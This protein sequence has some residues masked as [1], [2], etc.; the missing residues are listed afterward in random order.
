MVAK[1][2]NSKSIRAILN[3]NENKVKAAEAELLLAAGFPRDPSRLSFNNKLERMELLTRQNESTKTNAMHVMLNFSGAD[4]ADNELLKTIAIDYMERIGFGNQPFLVY[5]HY[6]TAHPH[7][8]IATV[9]IAEGGSRIETHNIGRNQS[10]K[11]RKEMEEWYGLV[12]ADEQKKEDVYQ[13]KPVELA[14]VVYGKA[15]TK[16]AISAVVRDVVD[17]YKFTSLPE[18]NAVLRQFNIRAY[19]GA[20]DTQMFQKGGLVYGILDEQGLPV[21]IPIKA[22]SIYGSPTLKNLEKKYAPNETAR[23]PYGQRLK[24]LLDKALA[25]A[26]NMDDLNSQLRKQG[27]RILMREN[28]AGQVYGI[29]FLDNA[30]RVVFN[31][32]DLGKV[33]SALQFM[34]RLSG[35]SGYGEDSLL[36]PATPAKNNNGAAVKHPATE[37]PVIEKLLDTLL[38]TKYERNEPDPFRKKKKRRLQTD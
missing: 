15:S 38:Y 8:H 17:S 4:K 12:K 13:L 25:T 11:A 3:Y 35:I 16:A 27:I 24:H 1:I 9:N 34:T 28:A 18:L 20:E 31:G 5:R 14:K 22:S 6:D 29:T 10:E 21:G 32:S 37:R 33:Y 19:R 2:V 36:I 7:I 23:K 30:T 26:R